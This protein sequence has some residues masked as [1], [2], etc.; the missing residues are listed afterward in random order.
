MLGGASTIQDMTDVVDSNTFNL[1]MFNT[2]VHL[3]DAVS[4][5]ATKSLPE[6]TWRLGLQ[7]DKN[8]RI[9]VKAAIKNFIEKLKAHSCGLDCVVVHGGTK[10]THPMEINLKDFEL[11]TEFG[12]RVQKVTQSP[13][14]ARCHGPQ[15][16]ILELVCFVDSGFFSRSAFMFFKRRKHSKKSILDNYTE[17]L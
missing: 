5:N 9:S 11:E 4:A 6:T 10:G 8:P 12:K 3:N 2:I 17:K 16:E 14:L 1:R 7:L 15:S 13:F